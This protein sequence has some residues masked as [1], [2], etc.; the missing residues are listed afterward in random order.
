VTDSPVVA[1]YFRSLLHRI[2]LYSP[3]V[4]PRTLT[5]Y[6]ATLA[7]P[8]VAAAS[9]SGPYTVVDV[10]PQSA[11][12]VVLS[13]GHVG[14]ASIADAV[15]TA[16]GQLASVGGYR[17]VPGGGANAALAAARAEGVL[18]WYAHDGHF[19]APKS[20][21]HPDLLG[22]R[23]DVVAPSS[24]SAKAGDGGGY[25]LVLG[26]APGSVAGVAAAKGRLYA[27]HNSVWGGADAGGAGLS[28][29]WGGVSVPAA[30]AKDNAKA[31]PLVRGALVAQGSV[32]FPLGGVARSVPH[33]SKVVVVGFGTPGPV[34]EADAPALIKQAAGLTDKQAEKVAARLA[35]SKAAVTAVA[36]AADAVKAL[37]M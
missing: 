11:R 27:A 29:T 12:G 3:E 13:V 36:S 8:G 32:T 25:T 21:P 20:E 26:A 10:D 5:V 14:L 22:V 16:A 15:A 4:F 30:V 1:L 34:K 31:L 28:A 2:P 18:S 9:G 33:P 19:Y 17:H 35:A 6:A 24:S 37:G 23:G 7:G